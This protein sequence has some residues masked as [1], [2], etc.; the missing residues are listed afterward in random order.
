LKKN[1]FQKAIS[2][3]TTVL[4]IDENNVK[5]LYRRGQAYRLNGDF[6]QAKADL[7]RAL[8]IAPSSK[9]IRDELN[10]TKSDENEYLQKQKVMF[11]AI[12]SNVPS[13]DKETFR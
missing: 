8:H 7:V 4:L 10:L 3:C 9:E 12:F 13:D 11:S 6:Q 5:A 1:D 2:T